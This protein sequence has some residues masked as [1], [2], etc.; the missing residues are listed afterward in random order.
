MPRKASDKTITHRF[1]LGLTERKQV[2]QI[3]K[4]QLKQQK[5]RSVSNAIGGISAGI[6]SM[7]L[8]FAGLALSAYLAPKLIQEIPNKIKDTV[9]KVSTQILTP[10]ADPITND[11]VNNYKQAVDI[12]S[13]ARNEVNQF[14]TP[15]SIDYDPQKCAIAQNNLRD[16]QA[17]QK[18]EA[19]RIQSI[20][21]EI[22]DLSIFD[23][24]NPI[25]T[26]LGLANSAQKPKTNT[27]LDELREKYGVV[28]H[29]AGSKLYYVDTDGDGQADTYML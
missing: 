10:V 21:S 17:N 20:T 13:Q 22:Q 24:A 25:G 8:L 3:A 19:D 5:F 26:L 11:V 2:E 18:A 6:G 4:D 12:T 28:M 27:R 16:A 23:F 29:I 15:S 7:G 9:D 14:C 1:E